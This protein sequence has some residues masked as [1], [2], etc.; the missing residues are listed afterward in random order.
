MRPSTSDFGCVCHS[1]ARRSLASHYTPQGFF[2]CGSNALLVTAVLCRARHG[3]THCGEQYPAAV[4]HGA[5]WH[6]RAGHGSARHGR[7]RLHTLHS[8]GCRSVASRG[9]ARRVRAWRGQTRQTHGI[10]R[11]AAVCGPDGLGPAGL[12]SAGT[13]LARLGSAWHG[14]HTASLRGC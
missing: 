5:A 12:G 11:G 10:S 7:A 8:S 4:G 1:V 6:G 14:K 13:C 9:E 2:P 3:S